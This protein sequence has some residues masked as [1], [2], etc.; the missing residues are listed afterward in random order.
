MQAFWDIEEAQAKAIQLLSSFVRDE[1]GKALFYS[2]IYS[3]LSLH[4]H[5]SK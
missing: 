3:A 1:S 2:F 4:S 5:D